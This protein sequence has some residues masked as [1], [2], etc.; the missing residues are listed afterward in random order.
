M[1]GHLLKVFIELILELQSCF[2]INVV[3]ISILAYVIS[4]VH[5]VIVKNVIS[6]IL[7]LPIWGLGGVDFRAGIWSETLVELDRVFSL[8]LFKFLLSIL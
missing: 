6:W 2:S 3:K 7:F 8:K 1:V 4:A 5:L